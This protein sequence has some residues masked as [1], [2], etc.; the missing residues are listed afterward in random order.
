MLVLDEADEML[1]MGFHEDLD[2]ILQKVP[3]KRQTVLFSATMS[4]S[5]LEL[6]KKYLNDPLN[7]KISHKELT[8]PSVEQYYIE[9]RE[10]SKLDV[11]SN[12]IDG[13]NYNLVLVFC[14]TKKR[15]A[16]LVFGLQA[17]GFSADAL[18][19]DMRQSERDAVMTKFR[20]GDINIMVATDI[21][22]RGIDVDNIEAVI[23]Y[24]IPNDD[25]YYVHRIGR[26][27]RAGKTGKAY[28]FVSG[29]EIYK[30]K[31]I[32]RYTKTSVKPITPP[33]LTDIQESQ[34]GAL[35][36]KAYNT[37]S[38]E[39]YTKYIP[40]IEKLLNEINTNRNEQPDLNAMDIA[41]ALLKMISGQS[42]HRPNI[43]SKQSS[44]VKYTSKN[45]HR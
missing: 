19:G 2:V 34:M 6:T 3:A 43:R 13:S 28:T 21:A 38:D 5:I 29:R 42:L 44:E 15:V 1:S 39:K 4:K 35:L 37:L 45:S 16:E 25:E 11:L 7:I 24:D 9:V 41:A 36:K 26:T 23:N 40:Y 32:Q 20:N 31:D 18:H 8:V 12:V 22:A 14:N 10:P 27:G 17:R 30:L 33:S